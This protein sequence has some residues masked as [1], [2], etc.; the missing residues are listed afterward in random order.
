MLR[1][2][3]DFLALIFPSRCPLCAGA[4][5]NAEPCICSKC[6][7]AL[8]RE[9]NYQGLHNHTCQRLYGLLKFQRAFSYLQ[10]S[11]QSSVQRLLHLVKYRGQHQLGRQLG[12]WFAAEVLRPHSDLYEVIVPVPLHPQRQ[13]LRGYNQ[14]RLIADGIASITGHQVVDALIRAPKQTTQTSLDRWQRFQ[15]TVSEFRLVEHQAVVN[16]RILLVDDVITT[17]ATIVGSGLPL[18]A[19]GAS[20]L[21]IGAVALTQER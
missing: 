3:K 18:V 7:V 15:N 6:M 14:S 20:N 5:L 13:K 9:L 11:K 16:K 19:G 8:P 17:G 21:V 1:L 10:F 4:R 2:A 12:K